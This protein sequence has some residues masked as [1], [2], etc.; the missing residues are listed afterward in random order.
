[1]NA[2]RHSP[3]APPRPRGWRALVAAPFAGRFSTLFALLV[4]IGLFAAGFSY[5]WRRWGE[6]VASHPRYLLDAERLE[7]TPQ[8]D[9]I[10]GDVKRD[11]MRDGALAG[12]K[13][14]DPQVTV[15]VARAFALHT[16]VSDVKRVRKEHPGRVIVELEYRR[17]VGMVEVTTQGQRGLLPVDAK[18]VLLPPQEFSAEQTRDYI[19]IV[20]G[21]T[22]PVGPVG[23]AW[24]DDRVAGAARI[25]GAL[26]AAWRQLDLLRIAVQPHSAGGRRR[27]EELI[28]ELH[29]RQG[30]RIIWGRSV[31]YE[32][33]AE[34]T[35]AEKT[36]R[37]VKFFEQRGLRTDELLEIDATGKSGLTVAP[38]HPHSPEARP[39]GRQRPLE[40]VPDD[41]QDPAR[42]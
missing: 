1:M 4:L 21:E 24:G 32:R 22:L 35:A 5:A 11:V 37:L 14:L 34:A 2:A 13:T 41:A 10:R 7:V 15:R 20:V 36:A 3:A 19:R 23:T 28:Y 9:W 18:G 29:A 39:V 38:L 17:P 30:S 25:A 40:I 42:P 33:A 8:P 31:G 12:L 27:P 16:W 26:G 6:T